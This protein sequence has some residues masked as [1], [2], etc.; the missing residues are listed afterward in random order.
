MRRLAL[1]L[2]TATL[3][4]GCIVDNHDDCDLGGTIT[5]EWPQFRL[6]DGSVTARCDVAG[7]THVDLYLNGQPV[8]TRFN[9]VDGGAVITGVASGS[10]L[11][12]VEGVD[13]SGRI[14]LRD[15][16]QVG[17]DRCGGSLVQVRPSEGYLEL[18]YSFVGDGTCITPGP[19]Y[20][21]FSV[22]DAIAGAPSVLID[23]A[24]PL[25]DQLLYA[26]GDQRG[27]V[28]AMPAGA[29]DLDWMEERQYPGFLVTGRNCNRTSFDV[30]AG[31]RTV[32]ATTLEDAVAACP[33]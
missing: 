33:R 7:V 4:T 20:L 15:E 19:S 25:G 28:F 10:Y 32:V 26:C 31:Q 14:L 2:A 22:F 3:G 6:A 18:A 8:Q 9:C 13:A 5:V 29:Y 11:L 17:T 24:S 23:A 16:V 27:I 21:W 12:T 1:L 30:V